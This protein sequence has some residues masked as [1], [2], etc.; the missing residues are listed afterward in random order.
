[1]K[2]LRFGVTGFRIYRQI[3]CDIVLY[4]IFDNRGHVK[5]G[6]CIYTQIYNRGL[7][8]IVICTFTLFGYQIYMTHVGHDVKLQVCGAVA[9]EE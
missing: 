6:S 8:E 5:S 1:M 7:C 9:R 2:G 4:Q 3:L